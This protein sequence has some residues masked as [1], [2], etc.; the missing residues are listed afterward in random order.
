MFYMACV[1]RG[2]LVEP[3][4]FLVPLPLLG[5]KIFFLPILVKIVKISESMP[6]NAKNADKF[7]YH[8]P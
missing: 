2:D 6:R 8:P 3:I 5:D 4:N 7:S 1:G